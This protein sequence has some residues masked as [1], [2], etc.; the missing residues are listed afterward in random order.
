M[1]VGSHKPDAGPPAVRGPKVVVVGAGI[2]GASMTYH[3]A[4]RG[5]AVTLVDAGE[6]GGGVTARAFS[7]INV[8]HTKPHAYQ[9]LRQAAIVDWHRIEA[10][11][12]GAVQVAWTGALSWDADLAE[13]ERLIAH[14]ATTGYDVRLVTASE[15]SE[16]ESGLIAPPRAAA[17]AP[18]EG[19]VDPVVATRA[20][21]AAARQ[22]GAELRFG[23]RVTGLTR[24]GGR[25]TGLA[26]E[27]GE[28]DA[29]MVVLAAG[30]GSA[31]LARGVGVD[32]PLRASP[33]TLVRMR[34]PGP[35][36]RG[37]VCSPE[38]EV[39]QAGETLMLSA[40]DYIDERAET[41]PMA[42]GRRILEAVRAGVRGAQ[43]VSLI[44]AIPGWRP[45]PEDGA[46]I[47]GF[48][49][50][51]DG[52]YLAVMHAGII[53]APV[54]GRLAAAEILDGRSEDALQPCRLERF[55]L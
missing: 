10:E 14:H 36:V 9:M 18:G 12:V 24:A 13:T 3:L 40:A 38:F 33:A 41:G 47:V 55:R 53:L 48:A 20:F 34:T 28:L 2:V 27:S 8:A 54:V 17:Y 29:E 37:I 15:I 42:I 44:D 45:M 22:A 51:L 50:G 39:R 26:L 19:S 6:P 52:L 30:V 49:P 46:P 35:L 16:L 31:D 1:H 25:V 4:A 23:E 43:D 5:V 21:C 11:L 7:W 32:L